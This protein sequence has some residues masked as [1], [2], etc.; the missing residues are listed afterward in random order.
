MKTTTNKYRLQQRGASICFTLI[1]LLVV[2]AIIAVLA[3]MLLPALSKARARANNIMCINNMRQLSV[4]A[5]I[6]L[7]EYDDTLIPW[8]HWSG[9]SAP[10]TRKTF[11]AVLLPLMGL[12]VDADPAKAK[13][14]ACP[15][16]NAPAKLC[17]G[18]YNGYL[19]ESVPIK[20]SLSVKKP[21]QTVF[22]CEYIPGWYGCKGN[23]L[24]NAYDFKIR[25]GGSANYCFLDG[26]VE[27]LIPQKILWY[28]SS[29]LLTYYNWYCW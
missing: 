2:I 1:E 23:E 10:D 18:G 29:G 26:R 28:S 3:S 6:Y 4:A 22:F 7:E 25:H 19:G 16:A 13:F 9:Y 12:P 27:S 20:K 8:F 17:Y 15:S 24:S 5:L 14:L 11:P 21:N